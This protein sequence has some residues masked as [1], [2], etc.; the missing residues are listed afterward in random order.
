MTTGSSVQK[1]IHVALG[2]RDDTRVFRNQVGAGWLGKAVRL[3]TG[4]VLIKD[5]RFVPFG[6]SPDSSDLIGFRTVTITP[7]MVGQRIAVFVGIEVKSGTGRLTPGQKN[8]MNMLVERGAYSGVAR[9]VD[10]GLRIIRVTD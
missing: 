2:S 9:S 1:E 8:W 5:P 6:L 3:K 7:D 10:D 4:D